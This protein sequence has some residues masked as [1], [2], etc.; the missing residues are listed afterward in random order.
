M[1]IHVC[2]TI[3]PFYL[4]WFSLIEV[5]SRTQCQ[6]SI[7]AISLNHYPTEDTERAFRVDG[8]HTFGGDVIWV[9]S[10]SS[11]VRAPSHHCY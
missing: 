5:S 10:Y 3:Y 9:Y 8:T 7:I 2:S 4:A 11:Q 6:L 1:E